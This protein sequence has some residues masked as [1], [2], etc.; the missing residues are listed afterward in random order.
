MKLFKEINI[1][2]EESLQDTLLILNL[3]TEEDKQRRHNKLISG[4]METPN[5]VYFIFNK[6][7][8]NN[9]YIQEV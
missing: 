5:E 4:I 3:D 8:I 6:G 2:N 7:E 1:V 9:N